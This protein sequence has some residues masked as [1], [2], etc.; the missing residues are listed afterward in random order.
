MGPVLYQDRQRAESFGDDADRY[1]RARPS[2]PSALV[3]DLLSGLPG[4]VGQLGQIDQGGSGSRPARVLDVGCGTGKASRLFADRGCQVV[5]VE[6]DPRM[7]AV[8]RSHGITVEDG[9][10]ERLDPKGRVFDLVVS[11]Q[12]WHWVDPVAGPA[13]AASVLVPGGRIGLFWNVAAL[14]A[15]LK[16]AM[17]AVYRQLAPGLDEYSVVLGNA[18]PD[19]YDPGAD[20]LRDSGRFTAVTIRPYTHDRTYTTESWTDHLLTHSDHAALDPA[21]RARLLDAI[22]EQIDRAG[23]RFVVH[24]DTWLVSGTVAGSALPTSGASR[25]R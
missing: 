18:G 25:R 6:P 19:R 15:D 7:A 4:A 22:A 20:S 9:S 21:A 23:G 12:A 13:K 8:A 17:D 24:Y 3:D 14:P 1:D 11:A 16:A 10:L 5:G 2:Y